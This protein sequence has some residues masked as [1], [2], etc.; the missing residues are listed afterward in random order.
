M[1]RSAIDVSH[2]TILNDRAG[3]D[4]ADSISDRCHHSQVV[5][6]QQHPHPPLC[7]HIV[8]EV[9]HGPCDGHVQS[10]QRLVGNEHSW[11]RQQRRRQHA[12]LRLTARHLVN[13]RSKVAPLR[14][15]YFAEGVKNSGLDLF[16]G[17]HRVL[18]QRLARLPSDEVEWIPRADRILKQHAD[19]DTDESPPIVVVEILQH[20]PLEDRSTGHDSRSGSEQIDRPHCQKALAGSGFPDEGH[21]LTF[22]N[23]ERYALYHYPLLWLPRLLVEWGGRNAGER[24][25]HIPDLKEGCH[26]TEATDEAFPY[27]SPMQP[28]VVSVQ[29]DTG[30]RRRSLLFVHG[31]WHGAWCWGHFQSWFAD[32]GWESHALD[33]RG[34]GASPNDRSLRFTRIKHYVEDVAGVVDSLDEPPIIIGHSMGSLVVQR[35]LES[36]ELPGAVLLAPDP[37]GGAMRATLRTLRRHPLKFFKANLVWDLR[38]LVEKR[39]IAAGLFLPHDASDDEVDWMWKQLQ[40]ESYLAYL[41]M[42]FFVR[43]RPQLVHTPVQIVAAEND[44]IFSVKE[45]MKVAKAYGVGL[46]LVESA[47]HDLM[48]GPR[49]EHAARELDAA[50]ESF[51]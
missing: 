1:E 10:R 11:S 4:D 35:Y 17:E 42:V 41:D 8:N 28:N 9:E 50:L 24:D 23:G 38:P 51:G 25:R 36:H 20:P 47:A 49:W 5:G 19:A 46:R 30:T 12:P 21:S 39:E 7:S 3:V 31:A 43:P 13:E 27:C 40:G 26:E 14:Q 22:T 33:L 32:R 48:L 16:L 34:H 6:D 2:G 15:P 29:P 44:R 37:I 18:H 45:S